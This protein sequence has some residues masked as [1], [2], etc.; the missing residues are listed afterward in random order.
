M[1]IARVSG[2]LL[3]VTL[4]AGCSTSSSNAGDDGSGGEQ[5]VS[6]DAGSSCMGE[7]VTF[8]STQPAGAS[9]CTSAHYQVGSRTIPCQSCL[10]ADLEA[11]GEQATMA[12]L[13]EGGAPGSDA[14]LD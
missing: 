6:I 2:A 8:C 4:A 9:E 13:Q 3:V 7:P 11:C 5:C 1:S 12:C 14:A 10:A